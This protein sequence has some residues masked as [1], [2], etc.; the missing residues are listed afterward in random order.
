MVTRSISSNDF[1]SLKLGG[2]PPSE[3][4]ENTEVFHRV[5]VAI[6]NNVVKKM[7]FINFN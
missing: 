1:N 5:D 6:T 2:V 7:F 4:C 3:I